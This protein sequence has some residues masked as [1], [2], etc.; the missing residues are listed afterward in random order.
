[1]GKVRR[2][3]VRR[4]EVRRAEVR[5]SGRDTPVQR[6]ISSQ[7]ANVWRRG[8]GEGERTGRLIGGTAQSHRNKTL[9]E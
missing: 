1:V 4:A 6:R 9:D 8:S 2:A 7:T 5:R 3:E